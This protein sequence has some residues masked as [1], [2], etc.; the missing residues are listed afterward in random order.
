MAFI[1]YKN[2]RKYPLMEMKVDETKDLN[3]EYRRIVSAAH[4]YRRKYGAMFLVNRLDNGMVRV[5]RYK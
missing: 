4:N 1:I 5:L 3:F 2:H